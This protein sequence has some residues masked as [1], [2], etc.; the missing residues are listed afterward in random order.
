MVYTHLCITIAVMRNVYMRRVFIAFTEQEKII[1]K[2]K[3]MQ[4]RIKTQT[5][6]RESCDFMHWVITHLVEKN[7]IGI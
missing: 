7:N 2:E 1:V 5:L 6:N 4:N 3:K